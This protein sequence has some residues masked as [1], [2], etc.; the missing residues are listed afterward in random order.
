MLV[1]ISKRKLESYKRA[2]I[3]A[4]EAR[5]QVSVQYRSDP[6]RL[7]EFVIRW[8]A[9]TGKIKYSVPKDKGSDV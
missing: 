2:E 8:M 5:H 6:N 3:V 4:R 1:E 9:V 7:A